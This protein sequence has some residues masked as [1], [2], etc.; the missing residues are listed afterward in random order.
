MEMIRKFFLFICAICYSFAVMG[1]SSSAIK[2]G[3]IYNL[4]GRQSALDTYSANGAKL[5]AQEI[6]ARGGLLGRSLQLV[7]KDGQTDPATIKKIA[8]NFGNNKDIAAVIGL[9]D[10]D[11]ALAAIPTL[12]ADKKLFITSGATS[13]ALTRL[14]PGWV[15][16]ACF[17]DMQQAQKAAQFAYQTLHSKSALLLSQ[18]DNSYAELLTK[19]FQKE[20]LAHGGRILKQVTFNLQNLAI[21]KQLKLLK[22]DGINPDII[23]VAGGPVVVLKIIAQLR[24]AGFHQPVVGGDSLD[25]NRL[26][27]EPV[28][29]MGDIYFTTHAFID[30]SNSDPHIQNFI[31]DYEK[32]YRSAPDTSFSGLGYDTV[33]LLA[34][35]IQNAQSTDPE[36]IRTALLKIHRFSGVTGTMG[37]TDTHYIPNKSVTVLHYQKGHKYLGISSVAFDRT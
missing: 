11:M 15:F 2:V 22:K 24:Q 14:A 26:L 21:A 29:L 28:D 17:S 13:P 18:T 3:V 30:K 1:A 6:N 33:M 19:Y 8:N 31:A 12:A 23:Y 7:I 9:S 20:Y 5:A 35:A 37:Y 4:T 34:E 10:T 36:Q 16:L 25:S 27:T 32:A